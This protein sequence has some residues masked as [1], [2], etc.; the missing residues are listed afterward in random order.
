[1]AL[2]FSQ[3]HWPAV[4]AELAAANLWLV[5]LAIVLYLT[6][7]TINAS[8]WW[9]L[10]RAQDIEV[11]FLVLLNY[12]F[13]GFFFNNLLPANIG[14][15]VM[16][17]LGLARYTERTAAAAASVVVDRIIGLSAYMSVAAVSALVVVFLTGRQ[18]LRILVVVA[19]VALLAIACLLGILLS[20]RLR[21]LIDHVVASTFLRR[22]AP[23]WSSLSRAFE[24]YRFRY[25]SLVLAFGIGLLG[26]F[27]TTLVNYC[28]S[29]S[30]GGGIPFLYILLFNALIALV[31]IVPI[32]IGGLGVNQAI[33]PFFFGMVGTPYAHALSLS[34]LMQ[35]VSILCSLPGG[36]L[37]L[38]WRRRAQ[39]PAS[40]SLPRHA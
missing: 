5:A 22:L 12:T 26:F 11:P 29:E 30:L 31:L 35:A 13:V 10:I 38:Y 6:A 14:G 18:D 37:W 28:L 2:V 21:G 20:R 8:K 9:V 33:Y 32:S 40:S 17:G 25:R 19:V 34:L 23:T 39:E 27:T 7:M 16:R 3:V 4:R 24:A 36:V 1:M 15:D